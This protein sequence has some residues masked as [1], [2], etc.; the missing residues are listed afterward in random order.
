MYLCN[1]NGNKGK[2]FL[3]NIKVIRALKS[4]VCPLYTG[5]RAIN[6]TVSNYDFVSLRYCGAGTISF[7]AGWLLPT[8]FVSWGSHLTLI[9]AN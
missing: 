2:A 7:E 8:H 9:S 1:Q 6:R 3:G 5:H 4:G